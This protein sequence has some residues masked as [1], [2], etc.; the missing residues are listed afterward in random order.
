MSN[1]NKVKVYNYDEMRNEYET[2]ENLVLWYIEN[3][4]D[5]DG[6]NDY[7]DY[8][9]HVLFITSKKVNVIIE[10]IKKMEVLK[11]E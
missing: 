8:L 3:K 6:I 7:K 11:N 9:T 10:T 4:K 2:I 1:K 5:Y